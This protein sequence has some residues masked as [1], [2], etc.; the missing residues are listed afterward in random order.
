[1]ER[2]PS[3]DGAFSLVECYSYYM[4][5]LLQNKKQIKSSLVNVLLACL[6]I[7]GLM[8]IWALLIGGFGTV[9]GQILMTTI[10]AGVVSVISLVYV[11]ISDKPYRWLG[12]PGVIANA[13]L[14]LIGLYIIW[15]DFGNWQNW[16]VYVEL[17]KYF[18]VSGIVAASCAHAG[19]LLAVTDN[20]TRTVKLMRAATL[21]AIGAVAFILI[22]LILTE[23]DETPQLVVRVLGV[24]AILDAVGSVATPALARLGAHKKA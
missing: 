5:T 15:N 10:L 8:G 12:I 6:G 18:T 7:A 3:K 4:N 11:A 9:H 2:V 22:A 16:E 14:L 13:I 20:A 21:A 17:I 23:P 24:F 1:M 19:I